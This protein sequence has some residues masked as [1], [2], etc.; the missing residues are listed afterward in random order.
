MKE[1]LD[2]K[3]VGIVAIAVIAVVSL[4]KLAEPANIVIPAI[5]GIAGFVTGG[6]LA[7][8]K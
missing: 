2:E 7:A 6:V 3:L 5:T 8:R 1:L 4:F